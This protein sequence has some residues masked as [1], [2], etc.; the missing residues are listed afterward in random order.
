MIQPRLERY[1]RE[2]GTPYR[3]LGHPRAIASQETAEAEGISG[4]QLAKSVVVDLAAGDEVICVVP[5][6]TWVDLDAVCDATETE[7]A[8][9]S[10]EDRMREL[11]PGCEVGAEPPFGGLWNLPVIFDPSLLA[12][13]RIL[14]N[15]GTHDDLIELRTE[16]YLI[17]ERPLLAPIAVMPGEPWRHAMPAEV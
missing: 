17:L 13:D 1:L 8:I 15:A 6:P 4:W 10:D 9:L 7:D 12:I 11:F 5:A 14:M 3:F 2:R 16:D